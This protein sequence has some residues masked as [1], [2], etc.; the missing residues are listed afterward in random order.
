MCRDCWQEFGAS[1]TLPDNADEII[2]LIR[3]LYQEPG[4]E[5]G[6]PLHVEIDDFNVDLDWRPYAADHAPHTLQLAQRIAD[7]MIAL[8]VEQRAAVLAKWEGWF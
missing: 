3:A 1:T 8:P 7:L 6:G 2:S 5:A 4:C